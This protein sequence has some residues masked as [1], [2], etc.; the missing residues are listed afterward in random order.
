MS[1]IIRFLI[2]HI[3]HFVPDH[4]FVVF[5]YCVHKSFLNLWQM[6]G[7]HSTYVLKSDKICFPREHVTMKIF[8]F[9]VRWNG[10]KF[11]AINPRDK[12]TS[13]HH[14]KTVNHKKFIECYILE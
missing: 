14:I 6:Y 9:L 10:N 4:I 13:V 8:I 5:D 1:I 7:E 11:I 2:S 12:S 3:L